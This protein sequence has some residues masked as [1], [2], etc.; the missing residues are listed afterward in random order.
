MSMPSREL[1]RSLL[2]RKQAIARAYDALDERCFMP[3]KFHRRCIQLAGPIEGLALDLG[4][5][6]GTLMQAL[7]AG[8]PQVRIV[9]CDLSHAL[10]SRAHARNP[11]VPVIEG[12]A[13]VLPFH[14]HQFD[15]VFMT[16]VL[17]HLLAPTQALHEIRRVLKPQG[18]LLL[19]VPNRDWV[20]YDRYIVNRTPF[21]PVDDHW[22]RVAE[23]RELL[24]SAGFRLTATH[25]AEK[26]Y[27]GGGLMHLLERVALTLS[28]PLRERMKR[29]LIIAMNPSGNSR[30]R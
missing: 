24:M 13:E 23:L 30:S 1:E 19:S 27:F 8:H 7:R 5:G 25:G 29:L 18:R 15:I 16:E 17:E 22:Y 28:Q 21:Q 12:D 6:P 4:C 11:G 3:I 2:T 26:L 9:G 10:C 20:K 14:D